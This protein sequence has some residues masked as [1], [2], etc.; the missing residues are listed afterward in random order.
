MKKFKLTLGQFLRWLYSVQPQ[1]QSFKRSINIFIKPSTYR[2]DSQVGTADGKKKKLF[3]I[4]WSRHLSNLTSV[5][6]TCSDW[7]FILED[8]W[9]AFIVRQLSRVVR[10]SSRISKDSSSRRIIRLVSVFILKTHNQT[11]YKCLPKFVRTDNASI[12]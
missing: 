10:R 5:E 7:L 8:A 3:V 4:I 12:V 2:D 1:E 6:K 9:Q 11:N